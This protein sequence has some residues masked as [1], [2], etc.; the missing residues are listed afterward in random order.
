EGVPPYVI[1]HDA[2]LMDMLALRPRDR[3]EMAAVSG[4]GDR[5]L[6]AYGDAF[7]TVLNEHTDAA[8]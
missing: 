6:E 3:Y 2:T 1:F 5:K 7:L 4:V 8:S